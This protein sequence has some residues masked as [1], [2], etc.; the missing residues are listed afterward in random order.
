MKQRFWR[1][2]YG[3]FLFAGGC[4]TLHAQQLPD[5]YTGISVNRPTENASSLTRAADVP[6]NYST[7]QPNINIPLHNIS[8]AGMSVG[9]GLGYSASGIRVD[10]HPTWCGLGWS[11]ESGGVITR[12]AKGLP[13][14][15]VFRDNG[16]HYAGTEKGYLFCG[17][18]LNTPDWQNQSVMNGYA[19]YPVNSGPWNPDYLADGM[20]DDYNFQFGPYSGTFFIDEK[21]IWRVKSQSNIGLEIT[22]EVNS[23]S[24]LFAS[25]GGEAM[26]INKMITK[27]IITTPDGMKY[28][29]GG[30]L[31]AIDYSRGLR[32]NSNQFGDADQDYNISPSAWYLTQIISPSN[33]VINFTYERGGNLVRYTRTLEE[34]IYGTNYATSSTEN[35]ITLGAIVLTPCY[36]KKIETPLQ[37]VEFYRSRSTQQIFD[38]IMW[39]RYDALGNFDVLDLAHFDRQFYYEQ[40]EVTERGYP[41][42]GWSDF[43]WPPNTV[44]EDPAWLNNRFPDYS[45]KLDSFTVT[46][47]NNTVQK[48]VKFSYNNIASQRLFLQSVNI[49]GFAAG[50]GETYGFDYYSPDLVPNYSSF[51]KD[52]WGYYNGIDYSTAPNRFTQNWRLPSASLAIIGTLQKIT[53]PT[54]GTTT[55]EYELNDY[56]KYQKVNLTDDRGSQGNVSLESTTNTNG[57]GL[58]I[59]RITNSGKYGSP[60]VIK[61][62][63]YTKDYINGGTVSSGI[64]SCLNQYVEKSEFAN[65]CDPGGA[66]LTLFNDE[67]FN[68][69]GEDVKSISYGEVTEV[70]SDGSKAVYKYSN[71]DNDGAM[72]E[73]FGLA[74]VDGVEQ[75]DIYKLSSNS[76]ERGLLLKQEFY[77]ASNSKVAEKIYDYDFASD[78]KQKYAKGYQRFDRIKEVVRD[79]L[80]GHQ[81][82]CNENNVRRLYPYKKYYYNIPLIKVTENTFLNGD[83]AST[84]TRYTYDQWGNSTVVES[85]TSDGRMT[86]QVTAFNSDNNYITNAPS[87]PASNG[88]HNLFFNKGIKN[89]PVEKLTYISDTNSTPSATFLTGGSLLTYDPYFPSVSEAKSMELDQPLPLSQYTT[90]SQVNASGNFVFDNHY[91]Q[92]EEVSD[93][94]MS[95]NAIQGKPETVIKKTGTETYTWDYLMQYPTSIT[96]NTTMYNIGYTSFEGLYYH[97][98]A[99]YGDDNTGYWT[100]NTANIVNDGYTGNKSISASYN[101]FNQ[102][103]NQIMQ[104][105][106]ALTAGKNYLL[107]FWWKGAFPQLFNGTTAFGSSPQST[108]NW[109]YYEFNVVGTGQAIN[110]KSGP[111]SGGAVP[112]YIDEVRLHPVDAVMSSYTY[113]P[114]TGAITSECVKDGTLHLYTYD[115]L[116]RLLNIK[117]EKGNVLKQFSYQLQSAN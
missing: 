101:P 97:K 36:L 117:D 54:S 80:Y 114:L 72:D 81:E 18:K 37:T 65:F 115:V 49:N 82:H 68:P 47:Y 48:T 10:Q 53:Y 105:N 62:Y 52:Q 69:Y 24:V 89:L 42:R 86:R 35:Y 70:S 31:N 116:G 84:F 55:F 60:D 13:D 16:N 34:N 103:F 66:Y 85:G 74:F 93:Y 64:L 83:I 95:M 91:A 14:D 45:Q 32:D 75:S 71:Y 99:N 107:S 46:D 2:V 15:Y 76:L 22:H 8:Y 108:S 112:T 4:Y 43:R 50:N 56:A 51:Q 9:L 21:G 44:V 58:R 25:S 78:R 7:G 6:V 38:G 12:N 5:W 104:S 41:T 90:P 111:G 59:K 110:I 61:N 27:F 73:L 88:L 23:T 1:I 29:F 113:N 26:R 30:D 39:R 102:D 57:G 63:Y 79:L 33:E 100:F 96:Q 98:Y 87:D 109:T 28:V 67:G 77:N 94:S 20:P 3:S 11:L 92:Q 40:N 19:Q 106:I 17:D